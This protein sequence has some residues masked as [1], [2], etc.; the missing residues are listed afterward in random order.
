MI[1]SEAERKTWEVKHSPGLVK[2]SEDNIEL[3]RLTSAA[4]GRFKFDMVPF[5]RGIAEYIDNPDITQINLRKS[6]QIGGTQL[7][8]NAICMWAD[9]DPGPAML[10]MADEDTSL[11]VC[12]YRI[13]PTIE[14][15]PQLKELINRAKFN[16]S[17]IMLNND[18]RL[19]MA[20]ASSIARTASR[21]IRYL[22][23]DEITKPGYSKIGAEGDSIGRIIQRTETFDNKKIFLLSTVTQEGD[24]MYAQEEASDESFLHF[25]PCPHCGTMQPLFF[26]PTEY[27]DLAGIKQTSGCVAW[28]K[29]EDENEAAIHACYVC[30]SCE[31]HIS[32]IEKNSACAHGV[33]VPQ[34][35]I[36]SKPKN[37]T[38]IIN[39]LYSLFPGGRFE[40][41]VRDF[42]GSK[43]DPLKLQ[44]FV[45][46]ALAEYWKEVIKRTNENTMANAVDIR[47]SAGQ[48]PDEAVA[49]VCTIDVQKRGF[50][51]IVRAWSQDE[52]SW[53]VEYGYLKSWDEV[54]EICFERRWKHTSGDM[55]VWRIGIDTGGGKRES[56][57]SS[58]DEVYAWILKNRFKGGEI[59]ACKGSSA[60]LPTKVKIGAPLEKN[61]AGAV[62]LRL[63]MI[64]TDKC[65]DSFVWRL[66]QANIEGSIASYIHRDTGKDYFDQI[67]AEEKRKD[68]KTG[69]E[70]W[71]AVSKNNHF[72]DCEAMQIALTDRVLN[73]GV[74][75]LRAAIVVETAAKQVE[76]NAEHKKPSSATNPWKNQGQ[77]QDNPWKKGHRW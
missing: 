11:E 72:F 46:N 24:T 19:L 33:W 43:N 50:W 14:R 34:K 61:K 55:P 47:F 6:T 39:R 8:V 71:F 7:I 42:L 60:P 12:K 74:A 58:T 51:Y 22:I 15:V 21:P 76:L 2:W 70:K 77:K 75:A 16:E 52:N 27:I 37:V 54:S 53:L 9:V 59:F 35:N 3:S 65:K 62:G 25:I 49:L 26:R 17:E 38:F 29:L 73:G 13:Q 44:T 40:A 30:G 32:T 10:V 66:E 1:F 31:Q 45:N 28:P 63:C 56:G 48:I 5:Y 57:E 41:L 18:F 69:R 67:K 36:I 23:M 64:D 4:S 20:W 68:R